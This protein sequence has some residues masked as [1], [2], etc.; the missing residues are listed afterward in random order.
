MT[1][2]LSEPQRATFSRTPP[3]IWLEIFTHLPSEA[4]A[5]VHLTNRLFA[6]VVRPLL[7]RH[8]EYHP[9]MC[10]AGYPMASGAPSSLAIPGPEPLREL[11][12]RLEC[13]GAAD[14]APLVRSCRVTEWPNSGV[15]GWHF[16]REQDPYVL[17]TALL[18]ILPSFAGLRDL[19][20]QSVHFTQRRLEQLCLLPNLA[21]LEVDRCSLAEDH[22]I[23]SAT[24]PSLGVSDFI[25]KDYW[26]D[27]DHWFPL[28]RRDKLVRLEIK[29]RD[30]TQF[31]TQI[32]AG[33]PW[34]YLQTLHITDVV[35]R[36]LRNFLFPAV[37]N[38]PSPMS[39]ILP[40]LRE[41]TGPAE[42]LPSLLSNPTLR[43]V[44]VPCWWPGD[45]TIAYFQ[46]FVCPNNV[47]A[48]RAGFEELDHT[49]LAGLSLVFPHLTE[50]HVEVSST[51]GNDSPLEPDSLFDAIAW[52][53][54][55]P[56]GL[57]KLAIHW[58]YRHLHDIDFGCPDVN[59][60]KVALVAQH[61]DLRALWV[62]GSG[63]M[64]FWRKGQ[65]VMQY[66]EGAE[67]DE[68][69]CDERRRALRVDWDAV[70]VG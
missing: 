35:S 28:L 38:F 3:E 14:V 13:W 18:D 11:L 59:E 23:D 2:T 1:S 6:R 44:I 60:L 42:Y 5:W 19:T 58:R 30:S 66:D 22:T 68:G 12:Q 61:P 47:T 32:H 10:I 62:D 67:G 33:D 29:L 69:E 57:Q 56:P 55:L 36:P 16:F 70:P 46:T 25:L 54:P 31:A 24:L 48:L 64:Y 4:L 26:A 20:L 7:F 40:S 37:E 43:R 63:T 15:H 53:S 45:D 34:S 41:Y 65:E 52:H 39:D 49:H 21:R 8:L 27:L 9:Y 17:L 50:L 51:Y